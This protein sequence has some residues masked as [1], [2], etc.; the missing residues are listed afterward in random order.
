MTRREIM[1][2]ATQEFARHGYGGATLRGIARLAG[3][4]AKLIHYY[5]GSKGGLFA[6]TIV[7]GYERR[8]F[9]SI[10]KDPLT[11]GH[12]SRGTRFVTTLLTMMESADAGPVYLAVLRDIG[13][14]AHVRAIFLEFLT[15][16]VIAGN[17]RELGVDHATTRIPLVGTQILGLVTVRYIL[18]VE[19]VA[20]MPISQLASI[21]G[22]TLERYLF[23][24]LDFTSGKAASNV[25]ESNDTT[26]DH[27]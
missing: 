5:F 16:R 27:Q 2:A 19:P 4:D 23:A 21:V 24:P 14:N 20:S 26:E 9:T 8:G 22:P 15:K 3:C 13:N 17:A 7:A 1:A 25:T 10:L 6:A 12:G 18:R 11:P